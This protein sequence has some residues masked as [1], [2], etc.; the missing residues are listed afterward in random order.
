MER[1]NMSNS[2]ALVDLEAG[3][4]S[5]EIYVD[6]AIYE[7]E[8]EKIFGKCWL[9]LGLESQVKG[10]TDFFLTFMGDDS[11][12]VNRGADG[13]IRAFLNSCRHRGMRLCR[14]EQGK[15]DNFQC[16][17]HGWVYNSDGSVASAPFYDTEDDMSD[18]G[19]TEVAQLDVC[20]GLIFATWDPDAPP[21][22]D[23]LGGMAYY[24][25]FAEARVGDGGLEVM[26]APQ[27]WT[28]D[29]N[30]KYPAENFSGDGPHVPATHASAIEAGWRKPDSYKTKHRDAKR[31]RQHRIFFEGNAHTFGG[32][33]DPAQS[34]G[35]LLGPYAHFIDD[36]RDGLK[37]DEENDKWLLTPL[38][39]G[40]V[41]PNL[42]FVDGA[43][44]KTLRVWHPR[45]P[46]KIEVYSWCVVDHDASDEVKED[47]K[48]QCLMAFGATGMFE[49]DDAEMWSETSR[50][51]SGFRSRRDRPLNYSLGLQENLSPVS[52]ADY[53]GDE[54]LP[55]LVSSGG[56]I[57]DDALHR[58]Y[59]EWMKYMSI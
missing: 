32:G 50:G 30:W 5:R 16:P 44:F 3:L 52:A 31:P 55:G 53:F 36:L 2:A 20:G 41:F 18:W 35:E 22:R 12:I 6:Q 51:L 39:V 19:L 45:G 37:A 23:Y 49:I 29:V 26:G 9:F 48:R 40:T 43:R 13:R 59:S 21:L 10:P 24:L 7:E 56:G 33:E 28:I 8:L 38:G 46:N 4:M 15:S 34:G 47:G 17:Y 14:V 11:V 54:D 25:D 58:F 57:S 42:S 1:F 27:R